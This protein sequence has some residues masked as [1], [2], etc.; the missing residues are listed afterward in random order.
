[1]VIRGI[2]NWKPDSRFFGLTALVNIKGPSWNPDCAS[3][4]LIKNYTVRKQELCTNLQEIKKS[5]CISCPSHGCRCT[6]Y[7]YSNYTLLLAQENFAYAN[8]NNTERCYKSLTSRITTYPCL[9]AGSNLFVIQSIIGANGLLLNAI[10]V[11]N[12]VATRK[13]RENV[14][15]LLTCNMAFC[16]FLNCLYAVSMFFIYH[17]LSSE[18]FDTVKDNFCPII[19]C[20]WL[21]GQSGVAM[22]SVMMTFERYRAVKYATKPKYR[23]TVK[24]GILGI[25]ISWTFSLGILSYALFHRFFSYNP[26]C[27]P[28]AADRETPYLF[29]F[30][31]FLCLLASLLYI[32]DIP[33]YIQI[34][35]VVRESSRLTRVRREALVAGRI[36]LLVVTN[37]IFF[38][39]PISIYGIMMTAGAIQAPGLQ[40]RVNILVILI[41]VILPMY[42]LSFNSCLNPFLYAFRHRAFKE[43][44]KSKCSRG[45]KNFPVKKRRRVVVPLSLIK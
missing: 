1:M 24:Q 44:L 13:L 40:T 3:C 26:I 8:C 21:L 12:V 17:L 15:L 23:L 19:G 9:S 7:I 42:C 10:I 32:T 11:A 36:A 25:L 45:V 22:T 33:L 43:A 38:F 4:S 18:D 28:I 31:I 20:F 2:K 35:L 37:M 30:S 27:V 14:S 29:T 41:P 34:Y 39:F 5:G 6:K 16:D